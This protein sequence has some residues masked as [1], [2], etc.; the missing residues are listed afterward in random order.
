MNN[1][2][3]QIVAFNNPYPPDFGGAIDV[4]YKIKALKEIGVKIHLHIYYDDR[5]D[6]SG[7]THLCESIYLYKK[8]AKITKHFSLLP[9]A[10]SSRISNELVD[11][12]N[13]SEAPI[14]F[15]SVRTTGVLLHNQFNQKT[16]VRC[17]NIESD[18][19]F[20]LFK[21]ERNWIK[22]VAFL[23]EGC[24]FQYYESV[25]EKVDFLFTLSFHEQSY[26]KKK[27]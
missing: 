26:Y 25:L 15:E 24:K 14:L 22:K 10:V 3:I 27:F 11:N 17:H 18:Y 1:N 9:Y 19:S 21:S 2:E 23:I 13:K 4:Y 6:V 8:D 16:A 12:L 7:L 20:G 5:N